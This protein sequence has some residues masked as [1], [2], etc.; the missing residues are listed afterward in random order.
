MTVIDQRSDAF[1]AMLVREFYMEPRLVDEFR[2]AW[3]MSLVARC[4]VRPASKVLAGKLGIRPYLIEKPIRAVMGEKH[5]ALPVRVFSDWL[6]SLKSADDNYR[7]CC[8]SALCYCIN[9]SHEW[10]FG[11]LQIAASKH[12]DWSRHHHIYGLIHGVEGNLERSGFELG[13]AEK[14]EPHDDVRR[15]IAEAIAL[16]NTERY[17]VLSPLPA[18]KDFLCETAIDHLPD[19]IRLI[20]E[21]MTEV[22]RA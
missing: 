7:S 19:I 15:R 1:R 20:L 2:A 22:R 8:R 5:M 13:L 4:I 11:A 17:G 18:K 16:G 12:D 14:A 3:V 9:G 21:V 6:A 10:A